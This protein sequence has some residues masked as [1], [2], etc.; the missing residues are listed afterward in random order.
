MSRQFARMRG[1]VSP[2]GTRGKWGEEGMGRRLD[3]HFN[4]P[5]DD[6]LAQLSQQRPVRQRGLLQRIELQRATYFADVEESTDGEDGSEGE[7]STNGEDGGQGGKQVPPSGF[8]DLST[9]YCDAFLPA[10][11]RSVPLEERSTRLVSFVDQPTV[12][13]SPPVHIADVPTVPLWPLISSAEGNSSLAV[14]GLFLPVRGKILRALARFCRRC[15]RVG[16]RWMQRTPQARKDRRSST[17]TSMGHEILMERLRERSQRDASSQ[18][19]RA[20]PD[21]QRPRQ[22]RLPADR[23]LG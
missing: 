8:A 17:P 9:W 4:L 23:L 19:V 1:L 15:L 18:V 2:G 12:V 3:D 5:G 20:A 16:L 22:F 13:L 21:P 6:V 11:A 7:E 14:D 10:R